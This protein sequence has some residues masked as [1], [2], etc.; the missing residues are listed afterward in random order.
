MA[1]YPQTYSVIYISGDKTPV[2][3]LNWG[4]NIV[5]VDSTNGAVTIILP[6]ISSSGLLL[7]PSRLFINDVG[8]NA[9][10]N[11]IT[12]KPNLDKINNQNSFIISTNGESVDL[13]ACSANEWLCNSTNGAVTL[14]WGLNG[15]SGTNPATNF[16]GTTDNADLQ[17]KVGNYNAGYIGF[18]GGGM[19]NCI[20]LGVGSLN[21]G[22][23]LNGLENVTAVGSYALNNCVASYNTG[24]GFAAGLTVINGTFNTFIGLGANSS[25]DWSNAT[26]IGANTTVIGD[27]KMQLGDSKVTVNANSYSSPTTIVGDADYTFDY[28]SLA[29]NCLI[30]S[31]TLSTERTV[32]LPQETIIADGLEIVIKSYGAVNGGNDLRILSF[33]ETKNID[34][35]ATYHLSGAYG[36]TTFKWSLYLDAWII[37]AIK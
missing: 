19:S 3:I 21:A 22:I 28:T 13:I 32:R 30:F 25:G 31:T 10:T 27:D 5:N 20:A 17:I 34:G 1:E 12:I 33:D 29:N 9:A 15:N 7:Y 18:D 14:A 36:C 35:D 2:Y 8:N 24:V 37:I 26:A 6:N 4:D 16:I 11:N 23:A